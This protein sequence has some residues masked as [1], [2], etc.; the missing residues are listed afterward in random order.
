MDAGEG[1]RGWEGQFLGMGCEPGR[2]ISILILYKEANMA[3]AAA[4][5]GTSM[6]ERESELTLKELMEEN[7][8][9]L[10]A[11]EKELAEAEAEIPIKEK[12]LI[13]LKTDV[14][15]V[16]SEKIEIERQIDS[17]IEELGGDEWLT[18]SKWIIEEQRRLHEANIR[19]GLRDDVGS[20]RRLKSVA[21]SFK[22]AD[23]ITRVEIGGLAL[24]YNRLLINQ[25]YKS[26]IS[27]ETNPIIKRGLTL[28]DT[29]NEKL[30]EFHRV[31]REYQ[32]VENKIAI[33]KIQIKSF[34][35]QL[36]SLKKRNKELAA[37]MEIS[38]RAS[39]APTKTF[40]SDTEQAIKEIGEYVTQY[41]HQTDHVISTILAD[42]ERINIE[43]RNLSAAS[44]GGS[45]TRHHRRLRRIRK[46]RKHKRN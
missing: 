38:N 22:R 1:G 3:A 39:S 46:T 21:Y 17:L 45:K 26:F 14:E 8:G 4:A 2:K 5:S 27:K 29:Y 28:F 24:F 34:Q 6:L 33:E 23:H 44:V 40:S 41:V 13:E 7:N 9:K 12:R 36:I 31:I 15:R 10:E 25:N 32:L 11:K 30:E 16:N 42:I 43:L 18:G 19:R 20:E 35:A 37:M